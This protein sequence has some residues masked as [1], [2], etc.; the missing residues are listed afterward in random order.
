MIIDSHAHYVSPK[1]LEEASESASPV[2]FDETTRRLTF[3]S[4]S[5]RPIPDAL[6]DVAERIEW[7]QANTID[8]QVVA[9]WMD[10]VGVDLPSVRQAEW[11]RVYNDTVAADLEDTP[12]L[13]ALAAL[14]ASDGE[15]AVKELKRAIDDLGF[16]GGAIPSQVGDGV[17]LDRAGLDPLFEAAES[18]DVP[19]FVHPFKVMAKERMDQ[20]FLFNVC[21]NPFET[22]LAAMRLFFSGVFESWPQLKILLAHTGGALPLLAGRAAHA[23]S[24]T[25]M[26]DTTLASGSEILQRFYYDTILHDPKALAFALDVIGPHRLT[27]GSD[28]PFPMWLEE[29][30]QHLNSASEHAGLGTGA[31][32]Q[33]MDLTPRE[34]FGI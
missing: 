1:L 19:L 33:V 13:R 11:C 24:H 34:L 7:M 31:A 20:H 27:L 14:P 6:L 21:G 26:F 3:P 23:S 15:T 17:D 16:V 25:A 22:T 8:L 29:P 10:I 32:K 18:M 4:G 2:A 30:L 28:Y 9:P 5:S 12:Q